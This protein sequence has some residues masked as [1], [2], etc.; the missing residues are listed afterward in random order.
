[1]SEQ[2]RHQWDAVIAV[3]AVALA[4]VAIF[5]SAGKPAEKPVPVI[6]KTT[7]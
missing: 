6:A 5:G 3:I 4:L 2:K 1:M 7:P